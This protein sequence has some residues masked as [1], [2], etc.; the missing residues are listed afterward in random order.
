MKLV[1]QKVTLYLARAVSE[2]SQTATG[3]VSIGDSSAKMTGTAA[4]KGN[5]DPGAWGNKVTLTLYSIWV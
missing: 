3:E 4:Y 5:P 2:T 1:K